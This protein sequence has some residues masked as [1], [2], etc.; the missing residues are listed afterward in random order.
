MDCGSPFCIS[1]SATAFHRQ[2]FKLASLAIQGKG[3]GRPEKLIGPPRPA[4]ASRRLM[5]TAI[6]ASPLP[7][8]TRGG[9]GGEGSGGEGGGGVSHRVVSSTDGAGGLMELTELRGTLLR[10]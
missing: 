10:T 4:S 8:M 1:T 7:S 2:L 9:S 3:Q 5:I 6:A